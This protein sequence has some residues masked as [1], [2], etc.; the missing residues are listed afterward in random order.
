MP[1]RT[2][3]KLSARV[4]ATAVLANL[5]PSPLF[6]DAVIQDPN[7][8]PPAIPVLKVGV[9]NFTASKAKVI[10]IVSDLRN[11]FGASIN[12]MEHAKGPLVNVSVK[13]GTVQDVLHQIR[14]QDPGYQVKVIHGKLLV[15]PNLPMLNTFDK[16][17]L[18]WQSQSYC[19][20]R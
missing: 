1:R 17:A 13:D 12:F 2:V 18:S 20:R 11:M 8:T 7:K 4:F 14:Q 10:D 9:K 5:W 3:I 15:Y 16:V 19:C 6:A